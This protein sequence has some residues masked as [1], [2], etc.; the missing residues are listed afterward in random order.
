M[1]HDGKSASEIECVKNDTCSS[2]LAQYHAGK[3]T[4]DGVAIFGNFKLLANGVIRDSGSG[5]VLANCNDK[6]GVDHKCVANFMRKKFAGSTGEKKKGSVS[7]KAGKPNAKFNKPAAAS[8]A[9]RKP[10]QESS[11]RP[12]S[13][14]FFDKDKSDQQV[15]EDAWEDAGKRFPGL[16]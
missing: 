13:S 11:E 9:S 5:K 12:F 6:I 2:L 10:K 1:T 14:P 4:T 8:S 3:A 16:K 7:E 15:I